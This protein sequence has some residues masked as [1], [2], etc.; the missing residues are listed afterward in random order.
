MAWRPSF[1]ENKVGLRVGQQQP[2]AVGGMSDLGGEVTRETEGTV[3]PGLEVARVADTLRSEE[4]AGLHTC[5]SVLTGTTRAEAVA[6][7]STAEIRFGLIG[8][9]LRA[10]C[11]AGATTPASDRTR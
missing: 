6:I 4:P 8:A 7:L 5:I 3:V 2:A 10:S 1:D 11:G 9:A